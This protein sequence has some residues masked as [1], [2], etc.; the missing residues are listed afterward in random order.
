MAYV[1]TYTFLSTLVLCWILYSELTWFRKHQYIR[2]LLIPGLIVF[3][4]VGTLYSLIVDILN[5]IMCSVKTHWRPMI[6]VVRCR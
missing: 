4:V 6:D 1:V 2:L 5:S 3:A